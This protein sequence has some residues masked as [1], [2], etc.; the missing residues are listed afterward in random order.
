M[1]HAATIGSRQLTQ[2]TLLAVLSVGWVVAVI[3]IVS[4]AVPLLGGRG[5]LV[6]P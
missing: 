6:F 3:A 2:R 4:L 1:D 5:F